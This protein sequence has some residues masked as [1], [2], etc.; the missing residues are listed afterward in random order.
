MKKQILLTL[1]IAS[2]LIV[3]VSALENLKPAKLNEPYVITQTCASC[4]FVNAS[5][6][7]Q[8]GIVRNNIEL[9]NNG[10]GVWTF[11]YIPTIVGR[12][13][14]T[15]FGDLDGTNT[16][17]ATFFEVTPSGFTNT[18]AFFFII[19]LIPAAL[20]VFGFK[21]EDNW[22]IVLGGFALVL[23]GLYVLFF[24]IDVIKDPNYTYGLGIIILMA[25]SY[26]SIRGA[27]EAIF[28]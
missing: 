14:V 26:F 4:T 7:N 6:S 9:S 22:V 2:L 16:S 27:W 1:L 3:N 17:F 19:L 15:G 23:V 18:I 8:N 12:H 10:S 5:I 28:A 24:G 13:D 11:T 21:I 25:G 20:I